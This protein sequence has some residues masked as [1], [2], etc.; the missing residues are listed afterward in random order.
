MASPGPFSGL[1]IEVPE[2]EPAVAAVRE[3]LDPNAP[4]GVPAHI[5]V[6]FPFMPP[7][8]ISPSILARLERLFAPVDPFR[9]RLERTDWFGEEVLWLAP[10]DPEPF[11]TLTDRVHQAYPAFPPFEGRFPEVVPHLTIGHGNPVEDLRAAEAS[12][13]PHLPIDAR[14]TAVNLMTQ[15]AEG[16]WTRTATFPLGRVSGT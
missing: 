15:S 5:T 16:R 3:H 7:Q 2:A 13:R 11:H 14:A 8:A 1:I 9:F 12:V 6:L 10:G 4:L